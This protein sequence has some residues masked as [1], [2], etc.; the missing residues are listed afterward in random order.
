MATTPQKTADCS[1]T[2]A[3][4][5]TRP[6]GV[7]G[8]LAGWIMSWQNYRMNRLAVDYLNVG[9]GD[10]VL[11]IGFG[12]GEAIKLLVE[13]TKAAWIAG[14][15]PSTVMFDQAQAKN[16]AAIHSGRLCLKQG[17]VGALPFDDAQFS[18]VF[19]VSTFH[20][21]RDVPEGLSEVRRVLCKHG[22]LLLSLRRAAQWRFP[23]TAPGLSERT[24]EADRQLL[25]DQGFFNV[26]F[27]QRKPPSRIVMI[28]AYT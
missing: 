22:L 21:W 3:Q 14:I 6:S 11:E 2:F 1:T 10:R 23:G 16:R 25:A 26:Q 18:R 17:S 24:L 12:S 28:L 8:R 4:Q 20:D 5:F 15:D 7:S 13:R 19:A 27:V 9:A